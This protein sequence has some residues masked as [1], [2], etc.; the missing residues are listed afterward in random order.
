MRLLVP[1]LILALGFG[2]DT[3]TEAQSDLVTLKADHAVLEAR[4]RL[5]EERLAGLEAPPAP[6][7]VAEPV[8]AAPSP[9]PRP[10]VV[11]A[12]PK[13]VPEPAPVVPPGPVGK[14]TVSSPRDG[15]VIWVDGATR[16]EKTPAVL[17]LP[18]GR[19]RVR[20]EGYDEQEIK[21]IE[22]ESV[23]VVPR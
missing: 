1:A 19:H 18:P 9:S 13:P 17:M 6:A 2:C 7:V 20:V 8:A 10:L 22:G 5:L 23:L 14:V 4:V 3:V 11:P 21:V 16:P 12:V 15:L